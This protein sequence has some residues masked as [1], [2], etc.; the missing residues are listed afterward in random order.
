M[1]AVALDFILEQLT[2]PTNP[3]DF[4]GRN[5]SIDKFHDVLME[6][7]RSNPTVRWVHISGLAGVGKSSLMRK[8]RMMT[9]LERVATGSVEVPYSPKKA[10]TFLTDLKQVI[11]EMAPEWR[12][13]FQRRRH[14]EIADVL[15]P[16]EASD[17]P[18]TPESINLQVKQF[19]EDLEKVEIAMREEKTQHGMFL[20]D[21]DRFANYGFLSLL[22]VIPEIAKILKKENY[23][24]LLV[25]SSHSDINHHLGLDE[26][27]SE[28]Y[29]LHL[30]L[31]QF[32]FNESE[33]M[34]RRRGKLVKSDRETVVST[35][36]RFPFDLSL[37][38]LIISKELDPSSLDANNIST[39]FGM[40][41]E[42]IAFLRDMSGNSTNLYR[43]DDFKKIH[44][45]EVL[46]GLA[47]ALMINKTQDGYFAVESRAFWELI[48]HVFKPIDPRT[49]VILLLNRMKYQAELGQMPPERDFAIVAEHFKK[50]RDNSLLFELSSQLADAAKAALDGKI[51][52][53]AWEMLQLATLGL[54]STEDYEKIADLQENIAKGFAKENYNYFAAKAYEQAGMYFRKADIEWRSLANYREA[55]QKYQK[56][57][58]DTDP[59]IYHYAIRSMLKE[60]FEAFVNANETGKARRVLEDAFDLLKD[61]EQHVSYFK[62]LEVKGE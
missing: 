56:V 28:D 22:K 1:S 8:F 62:K 48:S 58:E 21:L 33:L 54:E 59:K 20:D 57:A 10:I 45:L 13:F 34:I 37:R 46:D 41:S 51:V 42:E 39:T 47:N 36:T 50:I 43:I 11:D 7:I 32:D 19:F 30:A 53:T 23:S 35:S 17:L 60:S 44:S 6:Y 14:V 9:E 4:V 24:L 29:V 61:Y 52:Y 3:N 2:G 26:P 5:E 15:A 12:G 38:Q 25:T 55:G 18:V 31:D 16:P 40:T 49:E 27:G